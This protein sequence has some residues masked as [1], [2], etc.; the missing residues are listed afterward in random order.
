[1]ENGPQISECTSSNGFVVR[2]VLTFMIFCLCLA[3]MYA[4]YIEYSFVYP[5]IRD[6][7][8]VRLL[9]ARW[10]CHNRDSE[11]VRGLRVVFVRGFC[12]D[13]VSTVV[14]GL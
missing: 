10:R 1:V 7:R 9:W 5:T 8:A 14:G 6:R 4:V 12:V 11:T 2:L 3:W 13:F